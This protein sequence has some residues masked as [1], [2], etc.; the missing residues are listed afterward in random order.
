M[1]RRT[2]SFIALSAVAAIAVI[3]GYVVSKRNET[4][5][6]TADAPAPQVAAMVAP[7]TSASG[8]ANQ[9]V[10][11]AASSPQNVAR[12]I[13]DAMG[14][15]AGKRTTAIAALAEAPRAEAIPVLR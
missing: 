7:A 10:E 13:T 11:Q 3:S 8:L 12:W 5:A 4:A 15:D 14:G 1:Q 9:T 6:T 2:T